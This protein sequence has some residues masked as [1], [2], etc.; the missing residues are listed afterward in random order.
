MTLSGDRL[1]D[2]LQGHP[3]DNPTWRAL[4]GPQ[5][6]FAERN[7]RAARFHGDVS[8]FAAVADPSDAG[9]WADLA[10]LIGSERAVL[11]GFRGTPPADW[12]VDFQLDGVQLEGSAVESADD[13]EAVV[14]GPSDVPEM[15]DLVARTDPGPF[16]PRTV[17]LG[18]YLGIRRDG[19]LVAM[20]GERM[21]VPGW[22]EVSAV[23][24]DPEFRGQGLAGRL[25]RAVTAVIRRRGEEPYLHAA[26]RNTGAIRVYERLGFRLRTET[27]F[28]AVHH[29]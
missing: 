13:P 20:A 8:P 21:R 9:A 26:A 19:A 6:H 18:T 10:A 29:P 12:V 25:V 11:G 28:M 22:T 15:L 17:E 23:C 14:L 3:L 4:S 1:V 5:A 27:R 2:Q 16:R 24:T 7:D